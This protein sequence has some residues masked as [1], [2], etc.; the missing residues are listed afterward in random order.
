MLASDVL[1]IPME[2]FKL[3]NS[4]TA[5]VP[6]GAGT[7]GSRSLQTAGSAVH[8]ASNE[9]LAKAKQIAAHLLEADAGDIVVGDGHCRWRACPSKGV[10]WAE[11]AA[12]ADGSG[13]AARR[14][15]ARTAAPRARLRRHRLDVPVRRLTSR[16]SRSTSRPAR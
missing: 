4:D 9:V 2:N 5:A 3:V 13:Q 10:T 8:V 14:D 16:W 6:R 11:L 15:G 12:A 7:M 1:G